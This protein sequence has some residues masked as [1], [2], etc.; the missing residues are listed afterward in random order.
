M[1]VTKNTA[2]H[3]RRIAIQT[4]RELIAKAKTSRDDLRTEL[5]WWDNKIARLESEL[6][7]AE[8]RKS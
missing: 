2:R 4:L 8:A 7:A 3:Q 6:R 5:E 1:T